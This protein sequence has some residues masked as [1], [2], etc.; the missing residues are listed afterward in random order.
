M[1]DDFWEILNILDAVE[2][3][4][5][6]KSKTRHGKFWCET[7]LTRLYENQNPRQMSLKKLSQLLIL[8]SLLEKAILIFEKAILEGQYFWLINMW[9][10]EELIQ[11]HVQITQII[12]RIRPTYRFNC[13][14]FNKCLKIINNT[15]N[16]HYKNWSRY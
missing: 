14:E 10:G 16:K 12:I 7:N 2:T 1:R 8:H 6:L 13:K 9:I 4:F 5:I 15:N 3:M 11:L